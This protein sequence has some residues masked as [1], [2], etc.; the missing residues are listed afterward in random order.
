M[1]WVDRYR[2]PDDAL[3]YAGGPPWLLREDLA[4]AIVEGGGQVVGGSGLH[5]IDWTSRLFEIG[6]W[7]GRTARSAATSRRP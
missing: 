3:E 2:N 6:Y 1:P 5:R 7:I 4:V